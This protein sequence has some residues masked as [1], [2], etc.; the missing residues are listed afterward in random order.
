MNFESADTVEILALDAAALDA[1]PFG[2]VVMAPGGVVERYNRFEANLS[3][4]EPNDVIGRDF[5]VSVAPCTNN[6]LVRER[7]FGEPVDEVIEY[8]FSYRMKPTQVR[9]RLVR[10]AVG[11][12]LLLVE[13]RG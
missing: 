13:P 2:A 5:F 7:Y 4:L 12:W 9:L 3:G 6:Y 8:V 10:P 1:L 11:S